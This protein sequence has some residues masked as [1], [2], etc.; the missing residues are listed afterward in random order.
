MLT[1][2][3]RAIVRIR[4]RLYRATVQLKIL[5]VPPIVP[6]IF[7][8]LLFLML[9]ALY[10][11][12]PLSNTLFL[13][14]LAQESEQ[15]IQAQRQTIP[16]IIEVEKPPT[17]LE[18]GKELFWEQKYSQAIKQLEQCIPEDPDNPEIYYYI[19]QSYFQQGQQSTQ[20]RNIIKATR[21]YRQAY[22]VSDTAIEKYLKKIEENSD[23]DHTNDYFQL[24]YIYEIRS[25]IPGVD[26][27]QKAID[28]YQKLIAEK[29]YH[30]N[31]YY[32]LGWI[33]YQQENY[34]NAI[35]T[36]LRYLKPGLKSDFVYY[37]LGLSYDKI[38][39][40]E[41]AEYYFQ[42]ILKEFPDTNF[43]DLA[44]KELF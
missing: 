44:K 6:K 20:K 22:Q 32:H 42:L 34:Q 37:Y 36:F 17:C 13:V 43:A 11:L 26:E 25:L 28:I 29:P 10:L 5:I 38:D 33:Y 1:Y 7:S 4:T 19:G 18:M 21:Y 30:T 16:N 3:T 41:K 15:I 27:Y 35:D 39:E 23:K 9:L 8:T 40:K 24:A 14:S 31:V 12:S 2:L